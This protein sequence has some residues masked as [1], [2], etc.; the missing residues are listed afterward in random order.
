[1][2]RVDAVGNSLGV[3]RE[4]TKGLR[5]L[6]GWRKGVRQK[7][8]ETHRKIVGGNSLKGSGSSPGPRRE[9]AGRRLLD[10][11]QECR[12]RWD[13]KSHCEQRHLGYEF[14]HNFL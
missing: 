9:I 8:T 14:R 11:P 3:C 5:S 1:M 4:L 13:I 7:K 6:P 2:H 12:I 10:S